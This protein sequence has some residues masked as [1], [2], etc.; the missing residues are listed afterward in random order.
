MIGVSVGP[1]VNI[2]MTVCSPRCDGPLLQHKRVVAIG[3]GK[4][5]V[6]VDAVSNRN[7]NYVNGTKSDY[8]KLYAFHYSIDF[9]CGVSRRYLPARMNRCLFDHAYVRR[10][11]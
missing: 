8:K 5:D 11:H 2:A 9:R 3:G 6:E 7:P 4:S 1:S 10:A